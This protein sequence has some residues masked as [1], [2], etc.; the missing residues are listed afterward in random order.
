MESSD[1]A[2]ASSMVSDSKIEYWIPPTK[3]KALGGTGMAGAKRNGKRLPWV[4]GPTTPVKLKGGA[5]SP[6]SGESRSSAEAETSSASASSA[7]C[8]GKEN[9]PRPGDMQN[10]AFATG[11]TPVKTA[12]RTPVRRGKHT[13]T[14][15]LRSLDDG[16]RV[17]FSP[18]LQIL[19]PQNKR[20]TARAAGV[21]LSS[22]S[23]A[24]PAS[25]DSPIFPH[26]AATKAR[27]SGRVSAKSRR[28]VV[29]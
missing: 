27:A 7:E 5:D 18:Q 10:N 29:C 1:I 9:A 23:T 15:L 16:R 20:R 22:P 4:L 13:R 8:Q 14:K 11:Q 19:T 2:S 17:S 3:T 24:P 25:P 26:L 12:L 6:S 28:C 21:S